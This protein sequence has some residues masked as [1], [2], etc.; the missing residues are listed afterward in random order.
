MLGYIMKRSQQNA[1]NYEEKLFQSFIKYNFGHLARLKGQ[2]HF[3]RN[4]IS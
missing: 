3:Y 4:K 1:T 2:F